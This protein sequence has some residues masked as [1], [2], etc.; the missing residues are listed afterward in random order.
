[1][2]SKKKIKIIVAIVVALVVLGTTITLLVACKKGPDD[3]EGPM[4]DIGAPGMEFVSGSFKT[5]VDTDVETYDLASKLEVSDGATVI[6][7][8]LDDEVSCKKIFAGNIVEVKIQGVSAVD[9][10]GVLV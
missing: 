1:M 8:D 7:Y 6:Y 9:V 3:V 10:Y 5:T 4:T 2:K